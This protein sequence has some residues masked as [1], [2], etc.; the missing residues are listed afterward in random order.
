MLKILYSEY[1]KIAELYNSGVSQ[2]SIKKYNHYLQIKE[3]LNK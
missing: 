1:N 2:E 3:S